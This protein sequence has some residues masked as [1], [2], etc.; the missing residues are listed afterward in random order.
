MITPL[1]GYWKQNT[2][3]I[4]RIVLSTGSEDSYVAAATSGRRT[5]WGGPRRTVGPEGKVQPD[6]HKKGR[7]SGTAQRIYASKPQH[8]PSHNYMEIALLKVYGYY[9]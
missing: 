9:T 3:A 2:V 5:G 8:R 7:S 4:R 6:G 1:A